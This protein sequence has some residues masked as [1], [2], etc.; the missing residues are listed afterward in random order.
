MTIE[1]ALATAERWAEEYKPD[2]NRSAKT[3]GDCL[4]ELAQAVAV[5]A[6]EAK[7]A[8]AERRQ[9]GRATIDTFFRGSETALMRWTPPNGLGVPKWRC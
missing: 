8:K 3:I 4:G 7:Q 5:L 6:R 1:D 9:H 2:G